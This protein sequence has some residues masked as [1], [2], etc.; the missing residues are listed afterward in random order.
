MAR[1][2]IR[3]MLASLLASVLAIGL[4]TH[5]LGHPVM[6]DCTMA[7]ASS[8]P[9]SGGEPMHKCNGCAGDEKGVVSTA[10]AAFCSAVVVLPEVDVMPLAARAEQLRPPAGPAMIGCTR[11][12]DPYPPRTTILS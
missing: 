11:P 3:R 10:C 5:G 6:A 12:P 9:A 1:W 7:A 8:M 2:N 4:A